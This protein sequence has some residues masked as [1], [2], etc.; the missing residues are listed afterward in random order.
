MPPRLVGVNE[1]GIRVGQDHQRAKLTDREVELI[2][3]LH[4]QGL[5]YL[6]IATKFDVHK[7]TIAKICR[8]ERRA[9]RPG[10]WVPVTR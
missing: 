5:S 9:Q 6:T 10:R 2:L 3:K 8:G 4:E 7:S 1:R